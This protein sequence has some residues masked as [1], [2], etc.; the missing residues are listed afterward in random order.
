[1]RRPFALAVLTAAA[2]VAASVP[3]A[4][5]TVDEDLELSDALESVSARD[6]ISG[7]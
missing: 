4:A 5:K 6:A 1:M 3:A 2:L 7:G